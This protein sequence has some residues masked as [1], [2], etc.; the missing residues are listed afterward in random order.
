MDLNVNAFRIVQQ[1][2]T[3]NKGNKKSMAGRAGGTVGGPARA[4]KL[5]PERRKDI[6]K[7][8]NE[9]RWKAD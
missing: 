4:M 8:A 7:K 2:T 6:A 9:A 3:E 1:I 5:T